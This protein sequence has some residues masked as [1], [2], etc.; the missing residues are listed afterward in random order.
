MRWIW[1]VDKAR[2]TGQII[3]HNNKLK[4]RN[5]KVHTELNKDE[6]AQCC[7]S[8]YLTRSNTV[9]YCTTN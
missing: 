4:M 2:C 6:D 1:V 3:L 9:Q 8:L 7:L 5:C